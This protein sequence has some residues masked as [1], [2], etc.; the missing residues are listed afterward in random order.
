L[1]SRDNLPG[2]SGQTERFSGKMLLQQPLVAGY[3]WAIARTK[4][5]QIARGPAR[6]PPQTQDVSSDVLA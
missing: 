1:F 5:T 3:K 2:F 6:A 4:V